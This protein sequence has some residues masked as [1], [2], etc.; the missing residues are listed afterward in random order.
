MS[1]CA[2]RNCASR[3][4]PASH[5]R[6]DCGRGGR[7]GWPAAGASSS[8]C[9]LAGGAAAGLRGEAQAPSTERLLSEEPASSSGPRPMTLSARSMAL[10][11][12]G[13][14][15]ASGCWARQLDRS[16]WVCGAFGSGGRVDD[17]KHGEKQGLRTHRLSVRRCLALSGSLPSVVISAV[18]VST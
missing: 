10:R 18:S 13:P 15:S 17:Q 12:R 2:T 8:C 14:P 11:G 9:P 6:N 3:L 7:T 4:G 16:D 5:A 1:T